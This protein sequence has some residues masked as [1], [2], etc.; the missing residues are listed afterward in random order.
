M[1]FSYH[2]SAYGAAI[3]RND[4]LVPVYAK[5]NDFINME[6]HVG[7]LLLALPKSLTRDLLLHSFYK[8][9]EGG[10]LEV[11]AEWF[12]NIFI[13]QKVLSLRESIK[14]IELPKLDITEGALFYSKENAIKSNDGTIK[15]IPNF[16][17]GTLIKEKYK[18]KVIYLDIWATW[19][20]PCIA[21]MAPARE[22]HKLF[23]DK[24]V[25]F[26]NICMNSSLESWEKMVHKGDIE[27]ENYFFDQDLSAIAAASLLSGGF[28]T[29]IL[30]GK[31]AKIIT[32]EAP[33]PSSITQLCE[34]IDKLLAQ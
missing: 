3:Y 2:V 7:G 15:N 23:H 11:S 5:N 25:V 31:D 26:M 21:Q 24:D 9:L 19:C 13:Y 10:T 4:S 29:Y 22:V 1:M 14:A 8:K 6:K 28:P 17:L 27:G 12:T 18:A 16:D 30:I 20:G 33:R 32:R 34:A